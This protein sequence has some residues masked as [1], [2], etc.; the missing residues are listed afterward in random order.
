MTRG[1]I[2]STV[3]PRFFCMP[4]SSL[5]S[6]DLHTTVL[7]F[8]RISIIFCP[9][10]STVQ[11]YQEFF[12]V[13]FLART[14]LSA[15]TIDLT[16]LTDMDAQWQQQHQPPSGNEAPQYYTP[17]GTYGP[18]SHSIRTHQAHQS[19]PYTPPPSTSPPPHTP[20]ATA[21]QSF[22]PPQPPPLPT[23]SPTTP[24]TTSFKHSPSHAA[25]PAPPPRVPFPTPT[26]QESWRPTDSCWDSNALHRHQL[27]RHIQPTQWSRRAGVAGLPT[28]D[29][30]PWLLAYHG[31]ADYTARTLSH[32]KFCGLIP[33]R[34]VAESVFT[35]H[36]LQEIRD[37]RLDLDAIA[38]AMHT[39]AG[40]TIPNKTTQ[41][42]AFHSPLITLLTDQ[43]QA[44]APAV[45]EGSALRALKATSDDLARAREKLQAHGLELTPIKEAGRSSAPSAPAAPAAPAEPHKP[46]ALTD[47]LQPSYPTLKDDAPE[48]WT[49]PSIQHWVRT[50][51]PKVQESA[52]EVLRILQTS[53][54]TT[55]QLKE[56]TT[57]CG[58]P[59]N[60]VTKLPI[61]SLQHI[62]SVGAAIAG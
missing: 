54:V 24:T 60:R 6:T 49:G 38:E 52:Q 45:A 42:R 11:L 46:P 15:I 16:S 23:A 9:F 22:P 18:M 37:K 33:T 41:A 26:I 8:H 55:D 62:V 17:T 25:P 20:P 3:L 19:Q 12:T 4:F 29:V 48:A 27:H 56:A 39:K 1:T 59:L 13:S 61:K 7:T 44:H 50:F 34:S 35:T 31:T 53:K 57:R 14:T 43:L 21:N 5:P 32:G 2:R 40:S 10:I 30:F 58:L 28:F 51:E 36:L 47:V